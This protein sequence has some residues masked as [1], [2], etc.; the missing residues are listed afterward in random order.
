VFRTRRERVAN[1]LM[2]VLVGVIE[3]DDVTLWIVRFV[4]EVENTLYFADKR[5]SFS[6]LDHL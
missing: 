6:G 5:S 1:V 4:V 3:T 2:E